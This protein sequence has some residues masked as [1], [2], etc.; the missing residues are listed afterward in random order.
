M[1]RLPVLCERDR[2]LEYLP[3]DEALVDDGSDTYARTLF[4]Q[5]APFAVV[6]DLGQ[7]LA[8]M[9]GASRFK[10]L[11]QPEKSGERDVSEGVHALL[12]P[13][14]PTLVALMTRYVPGGGR[15]V[16][17]NSE[18]L[19]ER[20]EKFRR[21]RFVHCKDLAIYYEVA[22]REDLG[23]HTVGRERGGD[24]YLADDADPVLFFDHALEPDLGAV[25]PRLARDLSRV[26]A[27]TEYEFVFQILLEQDDLEARLRYL[28][29]KGVTRDDVQR[30]EEYLGHHHER[31]W[32][33]LVGMWRALAGCD[34]LRTA[35]VERVG[36]PDETPDIGDPMTRWRSFAASFDG[37][38]SSL[39]G[40]ALGVTPELLS[41]D[42]LRDG[43]P[44]GPLAGLE[45]GGVSLAGLS[46]R[47]SAAGLGVIVLHHHRERL[48][49]LE[50]RHRDALV[51]VLRANGM[52]GPDAKLA[53]E[54]ATS[55]PPAMNARVR[56]TDD[57]LLAALAAL[58][59]RHGSGLR[60]PTFDEGQSDYL[61]FAADSVNRTAEALEGLAR[62]ATTP[63]E[64]R[65]ER[66]KRFGDLRR[67]L[68]PI[69]VAVVLDPYDRQYA[70]VR[71]IADDIRDQI[72]C[73]EDGRLETAFA[74]WLH[75]RG[76]LATSVARS[77]VDRWLEEGADALPAVGELLRRTDLDEMLPFVR[78][79]LDDRSRKRSKRVHDAF[80]THRDISL[81]AKV[82]PEGDGGSGDDEGAIRGLLSENGGRIPE[83]SDLPDPTGQADD[84][85]SSEYGTSEA[86]E[87]PTGG[88]LIRR[89]A[90]QDD[91]HERKRLGRMGE[92]GEDV[93]FAWAAT[94]LVA[95][96]AED[97]TRFREVVGRLRERLDTWTLD[98]SLRGQFDG[99][100][101]AL[102]QADLDEDELLENLADLI[103]ISGDFGSD[104]FGFDLLA[105]LP[106]EDRTLFVEV[107]T[108]RRLK[109]QF[110]LSRRQHAVATGA[111]AGFGILRVVL[112][113]GKRSPELALFVDP[114]GLAAEG[115]AL[116]LEPDGWL[117]VAGEGGFS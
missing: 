50:R 82:A 51:G 17:L 76:R 90:V 77:V 112:P 83:E 29:P 44:S 5:D 9:L 16:E 53:V 97:R 32:R 37:D 8:R 102:G 66:Y 91:E 28:E 98:E 11:A 34:A 20:L 117:G 23:A 12:E 38:E 113:T 101:A 87:G 3:A 73:P 79:V 36:D 107:K 21:I 48:R 67:R 68:R 39:I 49:G 70:R 46:E 104:A 55:C 89:G 57:E 31:M 93:A 103:Q 72:A 22:G 78:R 27:G 108:G 105:W 96:Y 81:G 106:D 99:A 19:A 41:R 71:L 4:Q 14:L 35:G 65:Q 92:Q 47:L 61:R 111:R 94:P 1:K 88:R 116:W 43:R 54:E 2:R 114:V 24:A 59:E 7:V 6:D 52:D 25:V 84:G 26:L 58:L 85:E 60:P 75:E 74:E 13:V 45:D 64:R 15:P 40:V 109:D 56:V 100:V 115:R 63:E 10:V 30:A 18:T 33:D 110:H 62:E 95:L 86:E 69:M 42:A 80:R